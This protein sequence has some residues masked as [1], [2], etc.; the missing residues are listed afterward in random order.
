M[1]SLLNWSNTMKI[2]TA[3]LVINSEGSI[4]F[5]TQ[6]LEV[7]QD[8]I[9][10]G[11]HYEEM[12]RIAGDSGY[13]FVKAFDENEAGAQQLAGVK[14]FFFPDSV[15]SLVKAAV[16]AGASLS[17]FTEQSGELLADSVFGTAALQI[18][19]NSGFS[20]DDIEFDD[21]VMVA[22]STQGAF[23]S[24][25]AWVSNNDAGIPDVAEELMLNMIEH[26][27]LTEKNSVSIER[28]VSQDQ[29]NFVSDLFSPAKNVSV[30][31]SLS[32]K[33]WGPVISRLI[34]DGTR[35][36]KTITQIV[37]EV[38]EM[39]SNAGYPTVMVVTLELW[40]AEFGSDLDR[41]FSV[42]QF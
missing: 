25:W 2:K 35:V 39:A 30:L 27:E 5:I 14:E 10:E 36:E 33:K 8:Q 28:L 29:I 37:K 19:Q 34:F 1:A 17:Q 4:E 18:K 40:L 13:E 42:Y 23:V 3:A 38:V 41:E 6:V 31:G 22:R 12:E 32:S 9:D 26:L 20:D 11:C 16:D 7:T 24:S 15:D 21:R